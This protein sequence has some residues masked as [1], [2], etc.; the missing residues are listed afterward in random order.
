MSGAPVEISYAITDVDPV[1]PLAGTY[2]VTVT[3]TLTCEAVPD[4]SSEVVTKISSAVLYQGVTEEMTSEER[5][6]Q[7]KRCFELVERPAFEAFA[8]KAKAARDQI[9]LIDDLPDF[10][11]GVVTLS[12]PL[13][14]GVV[15][16]F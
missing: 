9:A 8:Q 10:T 14:E 12:V 15:G 11:G 7:R 2:T 5:L 4:L 6:A 3:Y 1:E 16:P 13:W